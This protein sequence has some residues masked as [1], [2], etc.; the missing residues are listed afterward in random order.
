MTM[1]KPHQKF[2]SATG[3]A[4]K[5]LCDR[6]ELPIQNENLIYVKRRQVSD[7]T[8]VR[9]KKY[10]TKAATNVTLTSSHNTRQKIWKFMFLFIMG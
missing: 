5:C 6:L 8:I 1:S 10:T 4:E 2:C 7:N 3:T 9:T